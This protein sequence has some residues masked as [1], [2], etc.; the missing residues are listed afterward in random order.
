MEI[1]GICFAV[2]YLYNSF[3]C[4][5]QYINRNDAGPYSVYVL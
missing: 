5:Y 2:F 1:F 3:K 4:W